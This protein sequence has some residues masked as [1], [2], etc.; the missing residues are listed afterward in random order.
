[1]KA[2]EE[3]FDRG[4]RVRMEEC[5]E[6]DYHLVELKQYIKEDSILKIMGWNKKN[7]TDLFITNLID[8]YKVTF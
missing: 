4:E 2:F 3:K 1:M 8:C 5:V 6:N 7:N